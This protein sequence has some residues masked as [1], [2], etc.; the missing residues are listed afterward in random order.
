MKTGGEEDSP[1]KN[2]KTDPDESKNEGDSTD[3]S[4]QQSRD[5]PNKYQSASQSQSSQTTKMKA[6]PDLNLGG[7]TESTEE[8]TKRRDSDQHIRAQP[9][10]F[11]EAGMAPVE[12]FKFKKGDFIRYM[13]E[14]GIIYQGTVQSGTPIEHGFNHYKGQEEDIVVKLD[15]NDGNH[16]APHS[17]QDKSRMEVMTATGRTSHGRN[18]ETVSK[19]EILGV[20]PKDEY[21]WY[22]VKET[23]NEET[24]KPEID[25]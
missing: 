14:D 20:S 10:D 18:I 25:E 24:G 17:E 9:G 15:F 4:Q 6:A 21:K 19:N 22:R 8:T 1:T 12:V 7:S 23:W 2:E 13:K 5:N 16:V 3:K 11:R